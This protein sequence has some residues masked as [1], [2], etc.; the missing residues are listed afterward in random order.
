MARL[1]IQRLSSC[2][3]TEKQSTQFESR[4][5]GLS[6]LRLIELNATINP[7]LTAKINKILFSIYSQLMF[8]IPERS[9][10]MCKYYGHVIRGSWRGYLPKCA[11]CG[12]IIQSAIELRKAQPNSVE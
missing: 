2:A 1:I 10:S 4:R 6:R 11:D 9:N 3:P 12:K 5:L 8:S 7:R